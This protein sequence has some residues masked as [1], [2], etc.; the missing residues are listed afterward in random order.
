MIFRRRN[1]D[2]CKSMSNIVSNL[3]QEAKK[4]QEGD[5]R[6]DSRLKS[7]VK[8]RLMDLVALINAFSISPILVKLLFDF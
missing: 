6:E 7:L 8:K 4:R 2:T 1:P 5:G 3:Q